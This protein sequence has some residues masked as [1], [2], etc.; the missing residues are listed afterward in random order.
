MQEYFGGDNIIV[1]EITGRGGRISTEGKLIRE[2]DAVLWNHEN[3]GDINNNGYNIIYTNIQR[4]LIPVNREPGTW[5]RDT[6][7]WVMKPIQGSCWVIQF[8]GPSAS[9]NHSTLLKAGVDPK[10]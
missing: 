6:Y 10:L 5:W 2:E 3:C 8:L 9:L 7:P 4:N 1:H